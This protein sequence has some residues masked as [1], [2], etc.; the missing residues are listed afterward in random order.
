MEGKLRDLLVGA[1]IGD[2]L[3]PRKDF[4]K[5]HKNLLKVLKSG[6][7]SELDAEYRDQARELEA[8][9]GSRNSGFIQRMLGEVK[10]VHKGAYRPIKALSKKS[11]MNSPR[12]FDY[13]EVET[14][15]AWLQTRFGKAKAKAKA[16]AKA[17][18]K[19]PKKE[20]KKP[21]M[22]EYGKYHNLKATGKNKE[23]V[24]KFEEEYA[25]FLEDMGDL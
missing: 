7:R 3:I 10:L 2:I 15:S 22:S 12:V 5:E 17:K 9:G 19:A 16:P 18:A 25:D 1:G 20:I 24:R 11:T 14:P 6:K 4:V 13:G 21:P 8:E 23:A